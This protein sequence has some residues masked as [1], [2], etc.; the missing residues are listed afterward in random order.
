M[1][2]IN[3]HV[4]TTHLKLIAQKKQFLENLVFYSCKG[5]KPLSTCKNIWFRWLVL[6]Q[7]LHVHFFSRSSL[8]EKMLPIMVRKTMDQHV[9]LDLAPKTMVSTSLDL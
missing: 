4:Q 5:Y 1:I 9:L 8:M 7:C 2:P 3:T 6:H